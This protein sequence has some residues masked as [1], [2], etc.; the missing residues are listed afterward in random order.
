M[1]M[2]GDMVDP[3]GRLQARPSKLARRD[4]GQDGREFFLVFSMV[5][6]SLSAWQVCIYI[7]KP[8]PKAALY[9]NFTKP[10]RLVYPRPLKL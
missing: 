10:Y 3:A 9:N 6:L 8:G 4:E 1:G 5:I 7:V 2:A